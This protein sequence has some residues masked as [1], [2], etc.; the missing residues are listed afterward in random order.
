MD[1]KL[2]K[3]IDMKGVKD[4]PYFTAVALLLVI[5]LIIGG[6]V[7]FTLGIKKTKKDIVAA[8]ESYYLNVKEVQALEQLK[9]QSEQAEK[10]LK[11]YDGILPGELGDCFLLEEEFVK[12]LESFDLVV[13]SVEVSQIQL[14]TMETS[15]T[16]NVT[17]KFANIHGYMNYVASQKQLQRVDALTISAASDGN[18]TADMV[19]TLLSESGASG[20]VMSAAE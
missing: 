4:S 20:V 15:F 3:N 17:G 14:Q 8:K 12:K 2:N 19:V 11:E 5:A 6:I 13:N 10:K 18:Y 9:A 7:Y 1:K 16:V